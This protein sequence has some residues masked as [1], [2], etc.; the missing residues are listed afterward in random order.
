M[1]GGGE[2]GGW[3]EEDRR[4]C[5]DTVS[6]RTKTNPGSGREAIGWAKRGRKCAIESNGKS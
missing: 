3:L 5:R 1:A 6:W 2:G 4:E